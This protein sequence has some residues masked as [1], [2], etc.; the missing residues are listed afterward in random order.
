MKN[1]KIIKNSEV[2]KDL[3]YLYF[4]AK[5]S[6]IVLPEY[7]EILKKILTILDNMIKYYAEDK[8]LSRVTEEEVEELLSY[9][10]LIPFD[11]YKELCFEEMVNYIDIIIYYAS[12]PIN[13]EFDENDIII[14][15]KRK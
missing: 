4:N 8:N 10:D 12:C 15:G 1:I 6:S 13:E 11:A 5:M 7:M 14:K 3:S 2:E 9:R